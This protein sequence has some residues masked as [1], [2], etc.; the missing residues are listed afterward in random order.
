[1]DDAYIGVIVL[2]SS[3]R[4]PENWMPCDGRR[5]PINQYQALYSL[6]GDTYGSYNGTTFALPD[7]RGRVPVGIGG[8]APAVIPA[9]ALGTI[10]GTTQATVP[11]AAHTHTAA[12]QAQSVLKVGSTGSN[13]STTPG[14]Y[15]V[16]SPP[17]LS[18][19]AAIFQAAPP[20]GTT[21]VTGVDTTATTTVAAAGVAD[22]K[23]TVINPYIGLQYLIAVN[24]LYPPIS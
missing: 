13:Q 3:S 6:I 21:S 7:L 10:G 8:V 5:L 11:V 14:G 4:I 20:N 9:P 2:W 1:M 18:T 12:T 16:A 19:A 23:V 24:G 22:A 15:L 17:T